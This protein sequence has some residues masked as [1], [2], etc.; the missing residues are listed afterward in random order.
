MKIPGKKEGPVCL[1]F[2]H[3]GGKMLP[4][5]SGT[6]HL[7]LNKT[8]L[9]VSPCQK[10]KAVIQDCEQMT[11]KVCGA[12]EIESSIP[13]CMNACVRVCLRVCTFVHVWFLCFTRHCSSTARP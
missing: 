11:R 6:F 12:V 2:S 8:H 4:T 10:D 1:L 9:C 7:K 3:A 5:Y 13:V